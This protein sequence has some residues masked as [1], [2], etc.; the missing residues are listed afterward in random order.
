MSHLY[1]THDYHYKTYTFIK[2]L[3][4]VFDYYIF[5]KAQEL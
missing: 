4:V 3:Y 1:I 2:D 5:N